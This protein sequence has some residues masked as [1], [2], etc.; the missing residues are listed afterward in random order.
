MSQRVTI[1][2]NVEIDEV[3]AET[4]R[5]TQK[6]FDHLNEAMAKANEISAER[7]AT[8]ANVEAIGEVRR[9]L[10]RADYVFLDISYKN[11]GFVSQA[12]L[13]SVVDEVVAYEEE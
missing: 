2:Y 7:L 11:E 12:P 6:A 9:C 5:L 1:Q 10:A 8:L 13:P 3:E 4:V